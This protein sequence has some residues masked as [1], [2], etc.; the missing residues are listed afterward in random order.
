MTGSVGKVSDDQNRAVYGSVERETI[1]KPQKHSNR[2]EYSVYEYP[3][4]IGSFSTVIGA[5]TAA[6]IPINGFHSDFISYTEINSDQNTPSKKKPSDDRQKGSYTKKPAKESNRQTYYGSNRAPVKK[7]RL[8]SPVFFNFLD[9][10]RSEPIYQNVPSLS[11]VNLYAN[12]FGQ[13]D[14]FSP[15]IVS[16][17]AYGIKANS[18]PNYNAP[19][20]DQNLLINS[21]FNAYNNPSFAFNGNIPVQLIANQKPSITYS[22]PKPN[23]K[24]EEVKEEIRINRQPRT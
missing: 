2:D 21:P 14:Q 12:Q 11:D 7:E 18:I 10:F 4:G 5:P 20:N 22:T 24:S 23:D 13:S 16:Q 6:I 1:K 9:S 15:F 3:N 17:S 19:S 8:S